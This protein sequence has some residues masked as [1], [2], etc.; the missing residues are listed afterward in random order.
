[1]ALNNAALWPL[2]DSGGF[3]HVYSLFFAEK[4]LK[5]MKRT[6]FEWCEKLFPMLLW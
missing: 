1:M 6:M 3:D 2:A 5:S 4:C